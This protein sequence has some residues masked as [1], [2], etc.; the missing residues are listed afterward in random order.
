VV[1][2]TE[3]MEAVCELKLTVKP[4]EAVALTANGAAPYGWFESDPK[5]IV[6]GIKP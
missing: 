3:Q 4:E 6:C 5:V 2:D 1:P